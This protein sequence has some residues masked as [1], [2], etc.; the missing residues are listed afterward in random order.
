MGVS[1]IKFTRSATTGS[2]E[3]W[4]A[5]TDA[6]E[7][8]GAKWAP[9]RPVNNPNAP[10]Q[11]CSANKPV[12]ELEKIIVFGNSTTKDDNDPDLPFPRKQDFMGFVR[13]P[14]VKIEQKHVRNVNTTY[15]IACTSQYN[16]C[17][18]LLYYYY[19]YYYDYYSNRRE[20]Q[21]YSNF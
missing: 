9:P 12:T 8:I 20:V 2:G 14:K 13:I 6:L 10:A 17:T 1:A 7:T 11:V 4:L 16:L 18:P 3:P 19:Y 15:C 21:L 5:P